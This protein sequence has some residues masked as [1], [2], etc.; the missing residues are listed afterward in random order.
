V[1]DSGMV[2]QRYAK[3]AF[4]VA[5]SRKRTAEF[6]GEL[7]A[8]VEALA[9]DE[10]LV[11]F[12]ASPLVSFQKKRAVL[13]HAVGKLGEALSAECA[14]FLEVLLKNKRLEAI[15]DILDAYVE[16]AD[17][18]AGRVRVSVTSAMELDGQ[19]RS[20]LEAAL[21]A[22]MGADVVLGVREDPSLLAGIEVRVGDVLYDGSARGRL[23]RLLR[24]LTT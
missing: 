5:T 4:R 11:R 23:D 3:A 1:A 14:R 9:R 7:D 2:A 17:A 12:W 8:A 10:D 13:K 15:G 16:M 18:A 22:R 24:R 21:A 6:A 19:Q 20:R